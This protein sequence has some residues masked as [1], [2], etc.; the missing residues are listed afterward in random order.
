M[1]KIKVLMVDDE[2]DFLKVMR[3]RM[4][5]WGYD[6]TTAL[7]GNEAL[8]IIKEGL[9]DIVILDYMMPQMDGISV[10]KDIRKR[11]TALPV[12]MFTAYPDNKSIE[13]AEDLGVI[14]FIPKLS[15]YTDVQ[16][17]L[18]SALSIAQ[19]KIKDKKG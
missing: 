8:N 15:T 5:S 6:I 19:N 2:V 4:E 9:I 14:A 16:L 13:G 10:L 1:K 17:T 12:I 3:E 7:S 18:K 11:D